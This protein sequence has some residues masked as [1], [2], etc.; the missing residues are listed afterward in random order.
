MIGDKPQKIIPPSGNVAAE[1]MQKLFFQTEQRIIAE[2][3]RKRNQGFVDYSEH[4]TL[5]RVQQILRD[6]VDDS[7]KYV[8]QMMA[9]PFM[10][11]K[12][13][14]KGYGSAEE[15][16][17][18]TDAETRRLIEQLSDNLLGEITEAAATAYQSSADL[19]TAQN[20]LKAAENGKTLIG[21]HSPDIYRKN[22]LTGVL[23]TTATGAGPLTSVEAVA[24]SI[25]KEGIPAFI[26]RAGRKWSLRDYGNMATRTT[27]RQAQTAAE[28]TKDDHD[29]YEVLRHPAPCRVC[30]I[31]SGRVYSKSGTNPNYP[32]LAQAFGKVDPAGPDVLS[33]TYL[34]IHPNCLVPGGFVLAE[35]VMAHTRR[36]YRGE[37][38]T[39]RTASGNEIAVTPNHPILTDAGFV[40][41]GA[42][43]EGAKIIEATGEYAR[44][45]RQAPNNIN[46]PTAPDKIGHS[47][48]KSSGGAACR[49]VGTAEQFHGDGIPDSEVDI[50]FSDSLRRDKADPVASEP[51]GELRF[52]TAKLG[53]FSLYA[54]C[55]PFKNF[56]GSFHAPDGRMGGGGFVTV[57]KRISEHFEL[58]S[59]M[60]RRTSAFFRNFGKR[61]SLIVKRKKMFKLFTMAF[62]VFF[63]HTIPRFTASTPARSRKSIVG[64]GAFD[65]VSS[66]AELLCNLR[67]GEPLADERLQ[68]FASNNVLIVSNLTH[69]ETSFY[70]G[71]VY[72]LETKYGFYTY[73]NIVTHNCLCTLTK[74]TEAGKTPEQVQRMRD[75][76]SFE[77]NPPKGDPR[78][79]KEIAAYRQKEKNRREL[80]AD[81]KEWERMREAL[82]GKVPA[83]FATFQKHKKLNDD[84]YKSWL[85]LMG[86]I[87]KP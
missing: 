65:G 32:S 26:D 76:S 52:P 50:V 29:L 33:N 80:R 31:Y 35:G 10:T 18:R 34:N 40:P 12:G 30:A 7:E 49:V 55:A 23:T 68:Y 3:T 82:G 9:Y 69:I 62:K 75:K 73:N 74:Y 15:I 4:A 78:T 37:V 17:Q 56:L 45:F 81:I 38:I 53:V 1:F 66:D 27:F 77:K 71:Y 22:V 85:E 84:K 61:F 24:R 19:I 28:L 72:N 5:R 39:L 57:V 64:F 21:R 36:H 6:M 14:F 20:A 58:L 87:T 86:G 48:M 8:P 59:N 51:I 60:S 54:K 79:K 25:E 41:A 2:I 42:L 16:I 13:T 44:F 67:T 63:G 83:T 47:F 11:G 43:H 46:T 70:D